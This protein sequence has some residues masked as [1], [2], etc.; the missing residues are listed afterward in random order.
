METIQREALVAMQEA[1]FQKACESYQELLEH[2]DPNNI[3]GHIHISNLMG[4]CLICLGKISFAQRYFQQALELAQN[5]VMESV[6]ARLGLADCY[7]IQGQKTAMQT[8]QIA[9]DSLREQRIWSGSDGHVEIDPLLEARGLFGQAEC[10][11]RNGLV[12]QALTHYTLALNTLEDSSQQ[13]PSFES[14]KANIIN[15]QGAAYDDIDNFEK[16]RI[17]HQRSLNIKQKLGD[18]RGQSYSLND[19]GVSYRKQAEAIGR[20]EDG[21]TKDQLYEK[22]IHYHEEGVGL[23]R[24]CGDARAEAYNIRSLGYCHYLTGHH[25]DAKIEFDKAIESFIAS[26]D[27]RSHAHS[28]IALGRSLR[29]LQDYEG[30]QNAFQK[31]Y[32]ICKDIND[33][34]GQKHALNF[35]GRLYYKQGEAAQEISDAKGAEQFFSMAKEVYEKAQELYQADV[36]G[37]LSDRIQGFTYLGLGAIHLTNNYQNLNLAANYFEKALAI[38]DSNQHRGIG[39]GYLGL[40]NQRYITAQGYKAEATQFQYYKRAYNF[41]RSAETSFKFIEDQHGVR[42]AQKRLEKTAEHLRNLSLKID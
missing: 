13:D 1:R 23:A 18:I 4:D 30:S 40:G 10:F 25:Q 35:L 17:Y 31:A 16:A 12:G 33:L 39:Y 6:R 21:E 8:Y 11:R 28:L 7:L 37:A 3:K 20:S 32:H 22:A 38:F 36:I 41:Y 29:Q 9:L 34:R 27:Q 15:G 2:L 14:L 19:L 24:Q 42:N 5:A 26:G